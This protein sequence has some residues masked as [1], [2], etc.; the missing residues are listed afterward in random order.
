V[1]VDEKERKEKNGVRSSPPKIRTG[2]ERKGREE[3]RGRR[4]YY[5]SIFISV[6]M[7]TR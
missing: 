2:R 4:Y 5:Y 7:T 3:R 1:L 6:S